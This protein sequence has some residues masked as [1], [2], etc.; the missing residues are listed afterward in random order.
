MFAPYRVSYVSAAMA[1]ILLSIC[2][3]LPA[4]LFYGLFNLSEL[5][6]YERR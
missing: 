5:S 2:M 6:T 1:A 3:F 4:A